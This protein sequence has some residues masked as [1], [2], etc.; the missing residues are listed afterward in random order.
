MLI[1]ERFLSNIVQR[2][3]A[4]GPRRTP[5]PIEHGVL[6]QPRNTGVCGVPVRVVASG[7][8]LPIVDA[9]P[10]PAKGSETPIVGSPVVGTP[11]GVP[12]NPRSD[13]SR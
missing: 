7:A 4:P 1:F 9:V 12:V 10:L 11:V 13:C 2:L 3:H 6:V 8:E 5:G